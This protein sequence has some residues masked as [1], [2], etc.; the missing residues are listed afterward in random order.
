MEKGN[1]TPGLY[2]TGYDCCGCTACASVCPAR[3]ILMQPDEEGF[4]Y[5]H[6]D[7][8]L[9]VGCGACESVC[10]LK[11]PRTGSEPIALYAAKNRDLPTR[12]ASSS[13]GVFSLLAESVEAQ[14][15]V[16]YGAA[17]DEELRVRHLRAEHREEWEAFCVSK[18]VQSD[19]GDSYMRVKR[20]LEEGR[21]VL[22]SGTPCQVEGLLR[23]LEQTDTSR[24]LTCDV[25]CHGVPSPL[26]WGEWLCLAAEKNGRRVRSVDFRAKELTG[27]HHSSLVVKGENG[28]ILSAG[29]HSENAF[30]R[31]YFRHLIIRPACHRCSYASFQRHADITLGDY[32]GIEKQFPEFDDDRGVSLVICSSEKGLAAINAVRDRLDAFPVEK[33]QCRQPNLVHRTEEAKQR[34][35]FWRL[36]R[37]YG[38]P[39][40][41]KVLRIVP[42]SPMEAVPVKAW[43]VLLRL[44]GEL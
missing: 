9:C 24:L 18:Y 38:L 29:T 5:P 34:G 36:F 21:K 43:R 16:I 44:R 11:T 19:L 25:V 2:R 13:G 22:F 30:S 6:M 14:G 35:L 10:Q 40:A 8:S 1:G 27:W 20:D 31:M 26:I 33:E 3:A 37:R 39:V 41:M 28:E 23:T 32:W 15:G 4:L 42:A 17:L 7:E 12:M